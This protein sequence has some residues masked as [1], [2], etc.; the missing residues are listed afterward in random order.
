[1]VYLNSEN[2][3]SVFYLLVE[4][5]NMLLHFGIRHFSTTKVAVKQMNVAAFLT[6]KFV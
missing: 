1:M 3:T 6:V 4:V 2:S 5:L